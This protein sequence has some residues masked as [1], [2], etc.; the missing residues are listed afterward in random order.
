M[1]QRRRLWRV[2]ACRVCAF[3]YLVLSVPAQ[4]GRLVVTIPSKVEKKAT[5]PG[6][7]PISQIEP[8][9]DGGFIVSAGKL[10]A[11]TNGFT[12]NENFRTEDVY[13]PFAI[14]SDG[15]IVATPRRSLQATPVV[16]RLRWDGS[17]DS[18]FNAPQV[19]PTESA[20]A[21]SL[22]IQPDGK[23][24]MAFGG[25]TSVV[26]SL[27]PGVVRLNTDGSVDSA[28]QKLFYA[29]GYSD[30]VMKVLA[31]R[32]GRAYACGFFNRG[33]MRLLP[34]GNV[35]RTFE[36]NVVTGPQ[37]YVY[38]MALQPDGK[39]VIFGGGFQYIDSRPTPPIARLNSDGSRDYSFDPPL[40]QGPRYAVKVQASGRI[41]VW[42]PYSRSV[43]RHLSNGG[44][45]LSLNWIA[46]DRMQGVSDIAI[47][48]SDRVY[49]C[50]KETFYQ[51]TGQ[52]RVGVPANDV[53][54]TLEASYDLT[55]WFPIREIPAGVPIEYADTNY[56]APT[57]LIYRT[58]EKIG[59]K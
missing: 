49:F 8:V 2:R 43:V 59:L 4:F 3:I 11:F 24:L 13:S 55:S 14:Q 27:K 58:R 45:D 50:Y 28:Y 25:G 51:L 18:T 46:P 16:V 7:G 42:S 34:D 41:V 19:G 40:G 48:A 54:R 22:A 12:L 33:V 20:R 1:I 57:S 17:I 53:N 5:L 30:P 47:D 52:F 38:S 36:A 21:L 32:D 15:R 9:G 39:L 44:L 37:T 56:P 26:S 35:D 31:L 6:I 23:I 29:D 10:Y